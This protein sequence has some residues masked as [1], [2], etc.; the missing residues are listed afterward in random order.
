MLKGIIFDLDGTLVDSLSVTFDAFNYAITKHG[1]QKQTNEQIMSYFG[2]GEKEIFSKIVGARNAAQAYKDCWSY[3]DTNLDN[4]PLHNGI[5]ELLNYFKENNIPASV[6]T[7]RSW[8][9]TE[10]IL[11]HHG[12]LERFVTIVTNDHVNFPKPSPEGLFLALKTMNLQPEQAMYI[13]D[14]PVDIQAARSAGSHEVAALWDS[15]TKRETL[16]PYQ[17]SYWAETPG[18]IKKIWD[19]IVSGVVPF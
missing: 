17:P 15:M 2:P 4:V 12:L 13:G 14:S 11:K 1:G 3:L 18:E 8:N 16:E 6:V 19:Q 7:G 9:T 10:T 5:G